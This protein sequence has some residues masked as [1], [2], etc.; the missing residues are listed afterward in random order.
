VS[1]ERPLRILV[2][3]SECAPF[4][5]EGALGDFVGEVTTALRAL[6]VDA[7]VVI[8]R[9]GWISPV[10]IDGMSKHLAPLGVPIGDGEAWCAVY[11]AQRPGSDLPVYMID[12]EVLFDRPYLYDPVGGIAHDNVAR[13]GVLSRGALQL[14]K[15]LGW[16]PDVIHVHDWPTAL[17]A[18]YLSTLESKG[19][20]RKTASV[21]TVHDITHQGRCSRDAFHI[22]QLGD[23]QLV[24]DVMEDHGGANLLKGA[25]CYASLITAPTH[26]QAIGMCTQE[27]SA[28]LRE[29]LR[30]RSDEVIGLAQEGEGATEVAKKLVDVY[31]SAMAKRRNVVA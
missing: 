21:L 24:S 18:V 15:H 8:P 9:Y 28:G 22:T 6:N 30:S 20:F 19:M 16:I 31:Q 17:T 25:L 26:T 1:T 10:N 7:R 11:E 12:H 13:F 27:G 4:A 3:A 29:V 5:R 14:A 2:V 23:E